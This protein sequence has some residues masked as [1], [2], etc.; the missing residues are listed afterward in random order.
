[1]VMSTLTLNELLVYFFRR[2]EPEE[3]E[4]LVGLLQQTPEIEVV[5][6]SAEIATLS[7]RYRYGLGIPTVDSVILATFLST[8]CELILTTDEHFRRAAEQRLIEVE[9]LADG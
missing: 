9:I 6:V 7:A 8:E 1:M 4:R 5:P 3:G 2:G